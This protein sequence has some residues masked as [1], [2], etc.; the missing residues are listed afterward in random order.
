MSTAAL[1]QLIYVVRLWASDLPTATV[2]RSSVQSPLT[3]ERHVF[4]TL[5][6]FFAFIQETTRA[7]ANVEPAAESD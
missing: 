7:A 2:W 3:G 4:A 6:E 1:P 5:D